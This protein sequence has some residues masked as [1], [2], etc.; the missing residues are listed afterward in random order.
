MVDAILG[1]IGVAL[2]VWGGML[3][4]LPFGL[5]LCGLGGFVIGIL[6]ARAQ[7]RRR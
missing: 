7:E 1:W 3:P 4:H 6:I 5:P 2:I